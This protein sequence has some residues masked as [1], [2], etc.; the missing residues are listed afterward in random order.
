[1]AVAISVKSGVAD[2]GLGVY[3]A[4][5]AM[6]LDFIPLA[7]EQYD[8]LLSAEYLEDERVQ[9]FIAILSSDVFKQ[10][11]IDLG[12]YDVTHTG[13]VRIIE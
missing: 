11:L 10:R 12:G 4:A 7:N 13:E 2:T 3:S 6:D 9:Q 1:M 8:F 5:K